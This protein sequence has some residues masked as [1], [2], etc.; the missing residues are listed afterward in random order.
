[1]DRNSPPDYIEETAQG[2]QDAESF[3]S[4]VQESED[5]SVQ[6]PLVTPSIIPRC[7][8]GVVFS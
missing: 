4:Y 6:P 3:V 8:D 2:L 5:K 7:V 1:M